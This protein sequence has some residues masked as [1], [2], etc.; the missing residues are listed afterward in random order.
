MRLNDQL[1]RS[2]AR[3]TRTINPDYPGGSPGPGAGGEGVGPF[4]GGNKVMIGTGYQILDR[5]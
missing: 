4:Q 1:H 5:D 3:R 2:P